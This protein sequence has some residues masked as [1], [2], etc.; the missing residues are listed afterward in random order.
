[1]EF[2]YI[3]YVQWS[4]VNGS[5]YRLVSNVIR[6][7]EHKMN[8]LRLFLSII[9]LITSLPI[10][11][12]VVM[13]LWAIAHKHVV[14]GVLSLSGLCDNIRCQNIM[15][16]QCAILWLFKEIY[17]FFSPDLKI[18]S[19]DVQVSNSWRSNL[20]PHPLKSSRASNF[21]FTYLP[22]DLLKGK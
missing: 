10:T 4:T 20:E 8:L 1:M 14:S 5:N 21:F 12:T 9:Y 2:Q 6:F 13:S 17:I 19:D 18:L 22:S 3:S 15:D 16:G 7:V 11:T